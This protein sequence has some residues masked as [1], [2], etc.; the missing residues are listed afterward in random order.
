ME[1]RE[2]KNKEFISIIGFGGVAVMN[3]DQ[4]FA[5]RLVAEAIDR[6]INYFDVAP[7][8]GNAEERL[9]PALR[10]KRDKIFLACKTGERTKDGAWKELH[11]SLKRLE[12]DYFDL[13][14]LH[15]MTTEE[16][17]EKAM[18]PNGAMEAFLKAKEEGKI[19]Y[20]GFSAHS[21]EIALKLLDSFNFDSI[22][23]PIN[24]VL[25]FN[26][27]FGPQVVEK[28]R[29]KGTAIL[30]IK[31]FAKAL[32][33]EGQERPY[34]KCWYLPVDDK[35]LAELALRFTLSQPITSAI[36]A[37]EYKLFMWALE[38]AEKFKPI[39]EE[40]VNYLKERAR[41]LNPIFKLAV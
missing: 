28:A 19:R 30:A 17:F 20:I 23:F 12:T 37:G 33:P 25:Y 40:E 29:E 16:D 26:A 9:G 41:G 39:T 32:I 35:E 24:W 27:N 5:N 15:A 31:P 13:Y 1:K 7:S 4:K 8:Y 21:V 2:Y 36:P 11:E 34:S 3:E 10:G 14:Q 18:G 38:I 22:L 6:G